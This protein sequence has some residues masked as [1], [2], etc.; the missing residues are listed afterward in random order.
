MDFESIEFANF[1]TPAATPI[2]PISFW[3]DEGV[4]ETEVCPSTNKD[5]VAD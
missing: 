4:Q 5:I 1:S 3:H 2:L